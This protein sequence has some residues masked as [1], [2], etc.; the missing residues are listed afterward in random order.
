VTFLW[1]VP[2]VGRQLSQPVGDF[3]FHSLLRPLLAAV[4]MAGFMLWME[5][6][7]PGAALWELAIKAGLAGGVYLGAFYLVS[8]TAEERALCSASLRNR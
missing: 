6:H 4:P 7:L 3:L 5:R 2:Y 8:L 1:I